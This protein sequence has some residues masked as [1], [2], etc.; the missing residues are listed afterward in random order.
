ML[1]RAHPCLLWHKAGHLLALARGAGADEADDTVR[2]GDDEGALLALFVAVLE[3]MTTRLDDSAEDDGAEAA[4]VDRY[5][6]SEGSG[7]AEAPRR[8]SPPPPHPHLPPPELCVTG[9]GAM[10]MPLTPWGPLTPFHLPAELGGD[11]AHGPCLPPPRAL[12]TALRRQAGPASL[13][14]AVLRAALTNWPRPLRSARAADV[15]RGLAAVGRRLGYPPEVYAV[16]AA[17][18][19]RARGAATAAA[20]YLDA[21]AAAAAEDGR[22]GAEDRVGTT[23]EQ[24]VLRRRLLGARLASAASDFTA[25]LPARVAALHA[26]AQALLRWRCEVGR[27]RLTLSNPR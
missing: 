15:V 18:L 9:D 26:L 25:P 13:P 22:P 21:A 5:T 14:L 19:G 23:D 20:L 3:S 16:L 4:A 7:A 6:T 2:G 11:T 1:E 12:L 17:P 24:A 8:P 27:C 10:P